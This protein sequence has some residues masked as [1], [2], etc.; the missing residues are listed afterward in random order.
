MGAAA[1]AI[2]TEA[3]LRRRT[4]RDWARELPCGVP[5]LR[6][7]LRDVTSGLRGE[8]REDADG[9]L[10]AEPMTRLQAGL[11]LGLL[12]AL[13]AALAVLTRALAPVLP[14]VRLLP[15]FGDA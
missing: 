15:G 2:V 13:V 11:S 10:P 1:A 12:A 14:E 6:V 3:H 4:S 5:A 9:G 8:A 7:A